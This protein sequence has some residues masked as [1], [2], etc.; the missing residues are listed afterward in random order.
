MMEAV[1]ATRVVIYCEED[2]AAPFLHW[3]LGLREKAQ[4]KVRVRLGRLRELG[5]E[6]RRP[7]ADYL[8]DGIYELRASVGNIHYRVLYFFHGQPAAVVSHG[9][10]KEGRVPAR[11]IDLAVERKSRY[12]RDPQKHTLEGP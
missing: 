8:R 11:E 9:I 4:D 2:G 10:A 1:P 6:L 5:H 12:T 7:E 3:L